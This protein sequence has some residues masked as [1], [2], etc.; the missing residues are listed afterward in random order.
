MPK[1]P[2]LFITMVTCILFACTGTAQ[3][4]PKTYVAVKAKGQLT[5]DG[6]A[7]EVAWKNAKWT[8]DFIDIEGT[9]TPK[10]RTRVKMVWDDTYLHFYAEMEEPHIW[11]T[12]KQ[13]DTVIFYNNDFEIFIDPDGDTHN[14]MEFE[15]NVLNTIWDL[16][17]TK[18][19][20]NQG[21]VLNHWNMEGVKSAVHINGT[22]NNSKDRDKGWAVEISIPWNVLGEA[23]KGTVPPKNQFWRINFSRVNWQFDL[24]N[25]RYGRKKKEN[26]KYEPEYNWV[27]SPQ[28]VINMHE[29]ERWGYV[30]FAEQNLQQD[31]VV[32][33]D[34][35]Y[36]KWY[37]YEIYRK[38]IQENEMENF[39]YP[40][41]EIK[42]K[43]IVVKIKK[44]LKGYV[45]YTKSPFSGKQLIIDTDG[46]FI[47]QR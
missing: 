8:S 47:E 14:Y 25:D 34:D 16:Y 1:T 42:G 20:R 36:I 3:Q 46:K 24:E 41:K 13:R 38:M 32:I 37:M 26:G 43:S 33:P 2:N 7:N 27:W 4:V 18:P 5:I 28:E 22:L 21:N 30:Y 31:K 10:Y 6:L 35:D 29:P 15:I 19:Y 11:G 39:T 44:E 12:L 45:V 9:L 23:S 40:P 17:L